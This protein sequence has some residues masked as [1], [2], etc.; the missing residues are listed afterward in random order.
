MPKRYELSKASLS[1]LQKLRDITGLLKEHVAR[2]TCEQLYRQPVVLENLI[3]M[4]GSL[5]GVLKHCKLAPESMVLSERERKV[6]EHLRATASNPDRKL[7][8]VAH[9]LLNLPVQ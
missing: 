9:D 3:L 6:I 2:D 8:V 7:F 5:K 4:T 1:E